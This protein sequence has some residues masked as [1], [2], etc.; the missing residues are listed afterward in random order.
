VRRFFNKASYHACDE[1]A[2]VLEIMNELQPIVA[3]MNIALYIYTYL[4][5][6][7]VSWRG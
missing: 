1:L 5:H 6:C 3:N 7:D 2:L 4:V